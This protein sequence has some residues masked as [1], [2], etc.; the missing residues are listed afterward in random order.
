MEFPHLGK[1]CSEST[2]KQLD[3]L[4]MKCDACQ[5]VFCKE[6][7]LYHHHNCEASY[8]KDVQVPV[9]PLCNQPVPVNRGEQPDIK[10]GEHIDRDCQSDPAKEKRKIY[11]N[12][13]S[14]KG[15]RQKEMIKVLCNTC[16]RNYCLKHRH[17]Q[18]HN[19]NDI[20]TNNRH[21]SPAGVAALNRSKA[22][23]SREDAGSSHVKNLTYQA[24]G[25][26]SGRVAAVQGNLSEDEALARAIQMSLVESSNQLNSAMYDQEEEDRKMAEALAASAREHRQQDFQSVKDKCAI[27]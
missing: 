18:D 5:K 3:F 19:C 2:C 24:P 12:K 26:A 7:V 8:K 22:F 27:V 21:L 11:I 25:R 10:V 9:C 15:C 4:P 20:N 14:M 13:C 1:N 6:H 17:P 23:Q 16:Q